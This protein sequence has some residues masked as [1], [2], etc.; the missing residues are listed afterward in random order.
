MLSTFFDMGD[1]VYCKFLPQSQTI[2]QLVNKILRLCFAQYAGRDESYKEKL[3]LYILIFFNIRILIWMK[4]YAQLNNE[5]NEVM[6]FSQY[7]RNPGL[8]KC[9]ILHIPQV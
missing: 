3:S 6:K 8:F 2:N 9:S 1:I 7:R 5:N 4:I